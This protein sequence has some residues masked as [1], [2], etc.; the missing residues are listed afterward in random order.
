MPTVVQFRRGTTAQ[1]NNF[2]GANGEISVD[3]DL[4]VLRIA[5]GATLGGFAL[6]G[7][8]CVQTIANKTYTGASL[9]VTGN[10]SGNYILGNGS[11]LTGIDA[12]SIQNGTS[13]VRVV[14]SGGNVTV[15]VANTSNVVVVSTTG[16]NITGTLNA[17]G[18]AN[19]GNIGAV[20]A[21][22][23][24]ALNAIGNITGSYILGNGSQL[25]GIDATS[26]Q[27][28]TSNVKVVSSGGNVTT[29][30]GG[31]ANVLVVT[32]TG[33]NIAGTL[34]VTGNITAGNLS[35]TSIVGT[36][37]TA[38]Q[39]NITSVGTLGSLTV[40][41]N[42]TPGGIAMS[43][44]NATIGNLYVSGT[45]TIAGNIVQVSGNSGQF[46]GNASTGFN[47]LYAGLPA[48]YTLL[49][50]SVVNFVSQFDDYS[51]INNQNQ[52]AG[53]TATSDWVLT[54]NNG[55]D[56]TYY[57]DF[58]IASSTY[59]GAVAILNNA[60]GN[61]V[62]PNDAY[63]YVTGNVAAGNPS[64][65]VLGAIDAGGQ[66]RFAVAGSTMANVA[67][68]LNAPN[69][70]SSNTTTGTAVIT[71]GVGVSGNIT[72][73][74]LSV[75]TGTI[76]VNNIVN[77]GSNA[78]GNIGSSTTYFNTVFAKAT[79]AQY[80]DVAEKYVADKIYPPGTV[81]EFGGEAEVTITTVSS[82]PAVAGIIS[83]NPAFI[84]NAGENN[85]N[86]VSV[87]LLGRVPCRVVGDIN[88]GDRLVSSDI[89]GVAKKLNPAEYQPGCILGKALENYSSSEPGVIEVI[90]GRL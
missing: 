35:G 8:N 71:G 73:G 28:G 37:T 59:N 21:V 7:Q 10:V 6:V 85:V 25:T 77:G 89:P 62:T 26:I 66:I 53:N 84:M 58:G 23:S 24:G 75:G 30:V 45:T 41:G 16:A 29:S 44:G 81:V 79:S 60:M 9:S 47:A 83:T 55:N 74:N 20:N 88:K 39:T 54:S 61:S 65:L 27:N 76:T 42:I 69:T 72:S 63:L 3:T 90:G 43:T 40:S 51:Q 38:S 15:G 22:F 52:S 5:D 34:G 57:A 49:P 78:T 19:V 13:N 2:L 70:T 80:A 4:H 32:G 33:A 56:S 17:S 1:N 46:F 86:A 87:A 14:S 67:L 31:T 68:K 82:S 11:Q 18:N 12:T 48:G 50:Q 64:D 36:L